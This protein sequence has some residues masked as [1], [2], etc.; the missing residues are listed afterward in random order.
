MCVISRRHLKTIGTEVSK[1]IEN[2]YSEKVKLQT[3]QKNPESCMQ[4]GSVGIGL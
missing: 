3:Q 2:R 1:S 4:G